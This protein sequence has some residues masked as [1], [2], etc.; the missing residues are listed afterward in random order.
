MI[1]GDEEPDT[2]VIEV[3]QTVELSYV[4]QSRQALDPDKTVFEEVC[5]GHDI[6]HFGRAEVNARA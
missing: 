1:V 5:A 3:G 4:D 2:G 6:L